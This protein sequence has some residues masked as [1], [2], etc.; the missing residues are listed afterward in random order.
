MSD[1]GRMY[2]APVVAAE[3]NRLATFS[4]PNQVSC[5]VLDTLKFSSLIDAG[6]GTGTSLA[7]YVIRRGASYTAFDFKPEMVAQMNDGLRTKNLP[8]CAVEANILDISPLFNSAD[9]VHERFVFMH[10]SEADQPNAMNNLL[11]IANRN[12]VLLEYNWRTME[13]SRHTAELERF[14]ECAFPFMELL[15]IDPYAGETMQLLV[16]DMMPHGW[17]EFKRDQRPEGNYTS[18]LI[19]LCAV[20]CNIARRIGNADLAERSAKLK[21]AFSVSPIEFVPPEIVVAVVRS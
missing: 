13:S 7:E 17:Y 14:R 4:Y 10:L 9:V 18:E 6:A 20:Q 21:E 2:D 19:T 12:I 3:R 5:R 11:Y 8:A 16:R 1:Q 15:H